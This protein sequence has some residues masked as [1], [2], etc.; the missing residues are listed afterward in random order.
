MMSI[1]KAAAA[2]TLNYTLLCKFARNVDMYLNR[3]ILGRRSGVYETTLRHIP[4]GSSTVY[5]YIC[6]YRQEDLTQIS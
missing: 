4:E 3:I 2:R 1:V 5:T 6:K